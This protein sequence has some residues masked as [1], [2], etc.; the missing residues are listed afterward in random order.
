MRV[1][2]MVISV[3]DMGYPIGSFA[4]EPSRTMAGGS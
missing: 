4:P 1:S 2:V 3:F